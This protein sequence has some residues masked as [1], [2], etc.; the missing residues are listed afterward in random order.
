MTSWDIISDQLVYVLENFEGESGCD[1]NDY[2]DL[3][4]MSADTDSWNEESDKDFK[5]DDNLSVYINQLF[6]MGRIKHK[7]NFLTGV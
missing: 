6:R 2:R 3:I 4:E 7:V 5:A 1:N